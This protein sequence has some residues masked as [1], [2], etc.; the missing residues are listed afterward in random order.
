[1]EMLVVRPPTTEDTAETALLEAT[2]G[3]DGPR[4]ISADIRMIDA[5]NRV[6][7]EV[8]ILYLIAPSS[9]ALSQTVSDIPNPNLPFSSIVWQPDFGYLDSHSLAGLLP[10]IQLNEASIAPLLN[11]LALH[12]IIQADEIH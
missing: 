1:M 12:Q 2:G 9:S 8:E 6:L 4:M 7:V 10:P 3:S 5:N 11:Q